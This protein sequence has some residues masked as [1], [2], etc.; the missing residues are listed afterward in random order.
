[1]SYNIIVPKGIM[2]TRRI[3]ENDSEFSSMGRAP[4]EISCRVRVSEEI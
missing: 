3:S 4:R 1:M 2:H